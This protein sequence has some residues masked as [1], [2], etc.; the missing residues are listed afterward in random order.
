MNGA[1]YC[2]GAADRN[3]VTKMIIGRRIGSREFGLLTPCSSAAHKNISTACIRGGGIVEVSADN[4]IVRSD[5]NGATE[6]IPGCTVG[7]QQLCLF[8][9]RRTIPEKNISAT[10]V[11]IGAGIIIRSAN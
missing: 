4:N 3:A 2:I 8:C 11:G 5:G 10:L 1:H 7:R 6:K 9:P